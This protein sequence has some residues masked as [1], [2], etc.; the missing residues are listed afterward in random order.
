MP[1]LADVFGLGSLCLCRFHSCA[2]A[3]FVCLLSISAKDATCSVCM[4]RAPW[5]RRPRRPRERRCLRCAGAHRGRGNCG[6][7]GP[8]ACA[9]IGK[10]LYW[11]KVSKGGG[12][13]YVENSYQKFDNCF[14]T[15]PDPPPW[16]NS[17]GVR[18]CQRPAAE[19]RGR[20]P[21]VLLATRAARAKLGVA[22]PW[23]LEAC[24]LGSGR[25]VRKL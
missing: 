21:T 3:G 11:D 1:P 18:F 25:V 12:Y 15:Y 8:R 5:S 14:A 4:G 19:L 16:R 23:P 20:G 2:L 6:G 13:G 9:L 7:G 17:I 22:L 24:G 10:F